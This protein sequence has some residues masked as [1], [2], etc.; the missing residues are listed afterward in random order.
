[1]SIELNGYPTPELTGYLAPERIRYLTPEL[2]GYLS[3]DLTSFEERLKGS[4]LDTTT[5]STAT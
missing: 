5:V 2:I 1:M 4:C 3:Q